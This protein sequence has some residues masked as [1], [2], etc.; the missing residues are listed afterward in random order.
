[1]TVNIEWDEKKARA[2][3]LKHGVSFEEAETALRDPLVAV[4]PDP[5]HS[6]DEEREIAAGVSSSGRLLLISFTQR[7]DS[8]RII[9]ARKLTAYERS[10][11]EEKSYP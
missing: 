5:D 7:D 9:S 1:V 11:Y 10:L 6:A 8:I 4:G 2:N 3:L